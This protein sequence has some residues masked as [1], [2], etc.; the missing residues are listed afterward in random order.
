VT[1]V[2]ALAEVDDLVVVLDG[3]DSASI[4]PLI[5]CTMSAGGRAAATREDA[6]RHFSDALEANRRIGARAWLAHTEHD[7]A[8]LLL[9]RG[10]PG[11]GERA[12]TLLARPTT[13]PGG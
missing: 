12:Q 2:L 10:G 3:R 7:Y 9:A 6:E 8:Q 13:P 5:T 11:D 1:G 4:T